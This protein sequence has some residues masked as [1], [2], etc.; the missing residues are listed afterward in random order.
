MKRV[1][2]TR[3][4][5]G[6][7]LDTHRHREGYVALVLQ[8]EYVE[9]SADG[10]CECAPGTVIVHPPFHAHANRFRG[11]DTVNVLNVRLAEGVRAGPARAARLD[12]AEASTLSSMMARDA[13]GS[14]RIVVEEIVPRRIA[15]NGAGWAA[16]L[17]AALHSDDDR[18][19]AALASAVGVSPEH[20]SRHLRRLIGLAPSEV[21]AEARLRRALRA[22]ADGASPAAAAAEAGFCDQS[23][24]CRAFR[25]QLGLTPSKL[26][27]SLS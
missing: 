11:A 24:M 14:A 7:S 8:G 27:A 1:F 19:I 5:G 26:A 17:I 23:H 18:P 15:S 20:A 6:S 2:E 25:R 10:R 16:R 9:L 13:R 3:H 4:A 22:L 12:A 21:R